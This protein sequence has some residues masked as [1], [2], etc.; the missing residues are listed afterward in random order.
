MLCNFRKILKKKKIKLN[1]KNYFD[2]LLYKCKKER[3]RLWRDRKE[4]RIFFQ[5]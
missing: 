1:F 4:Q 3:L 2:I 5:E